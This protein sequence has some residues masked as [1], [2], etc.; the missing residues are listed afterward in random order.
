MSLHG[1][2][3]DGKDKMAEGMVDHVVDNV[4][5]LKLTDLQTFEEAFKREGVTKG[6]H[7]TD[8]NPEDLRSLG[9]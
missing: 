8:I 4:E 3:A 5:L 7:I 6:R 1:V 2:E 9:Q